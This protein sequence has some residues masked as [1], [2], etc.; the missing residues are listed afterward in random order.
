M[1]LLGFSVSPFVHK[2][3][4]GTQQELDR[5]ILTAGFCEAN[6]IMTVSFTFTWSTVVRQSV[7]GK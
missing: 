5:A 1:A 6:N 4:T 3:H 7:I 2:L